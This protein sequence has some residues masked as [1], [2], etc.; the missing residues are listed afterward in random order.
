MN[1]VQIFVETV[2]HAQIAAPSLE[3]MLLLGILTLSLVFRAIRTGLLIA[4]L[5]A[6][7]W[8]WIFVSETL[9][10]KDTVYLQAYAFLGVFVM[11]LGIIGMM[12]GEN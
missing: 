9:A 3:L 5:F 2:R 8:G 7:R 6:F 12:H 11:I 10:Q 4:Y 1:R